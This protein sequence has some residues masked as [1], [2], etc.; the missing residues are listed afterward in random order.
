MSAVVTGADVVAVDF[1]LGA[2]VVVVFLLLFLEDPVE[3]D[4][5]EVQSVSFLPINQPSCFSPRL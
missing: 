5:D 1:L 2:G 3:D 4:D